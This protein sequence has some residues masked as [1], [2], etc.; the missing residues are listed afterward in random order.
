MGILTLL[1]SLAVLG[2]G[3]ATTVSLPNHN[4]RFDTNGN[5]LDAHDGRLY[6]FDHQ[7]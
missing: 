2:L 4:L 3:A 1:A 6:Y 7:Y 5:L